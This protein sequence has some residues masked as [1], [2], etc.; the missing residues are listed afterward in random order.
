MEYRRLGRAGI[1]LSELSFGSWLTFG[2]Q[3]DLDDVR[4][5]MRQAF[6]AGVNF[7]DNA[8]AYADGKAEEL[9][10]EALRDYRREDVVVSTKIYWG[11][12][13]AN[14][15]GLSWKHLQ[16]GVRGALRRLQ[17]DYIDLVFCHRPDPDTPIDETVRAMDCIVR[18]GQAFYWGTSEWSGE[19][20]AE[21]HRVARE[22]HCIPP[23]MEQP[24]Y[25]M[26]T[27]DKAEREF[28][29]LYDAY[30]M[31]T[32]IWSPLASGILTGKYNDGI[33]DGTRL[34]N[35]TWLQERVTPERL[36]MVKKLAG[37]ASDV[38]GTLAQLAIAWCLKRDFVSTVILGA[39]T[40]EQL[41]ENL[42]APALVEKLDIDVLTAIE[43]IL[44]NKPERG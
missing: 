7:F 27:R 42:A 40:S 34:A 6:D 25:N 10:G 4:S 11:G 22:L 31:G 14:D 29:P 20:I 24:Q 38:G 12:K 8:E 17:L 21:A 16:E 43:R 5:L 39:T 1:K 37:V 18:G 35:Q 33:P 30:G 32:T 19:Q 15:T 2:S 44:Q 28:V 36:A 41:A 23:V 3:L 26:F 13:G 9:M